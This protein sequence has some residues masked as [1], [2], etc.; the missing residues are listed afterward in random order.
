MF[1][2]VAPFQPDDKSKIQ[3]SKR[4]DFIFITLTMAKS[5]RTALHTQSS[6]GTVTLS[7]CNLWLPPASQCYQTLSRVSTAN[8]CEHSNAY[9]YFW[10]I[11]CAWVFVTFSTKSRVISCKSFRDILHK[12]LS[13]RHSSFKVTYL[14][15]PDIVSSAYR[16][17]SNTKFVPSHTRQN[18]DRCFCES[19]TRISLRMMFCV[20]TA[21][22]PVCCLHD[23]HR[24]RA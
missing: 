4:C 17:H 18:G 11:L 13:R 1:P 8:F 6:N 3:L 24:A 15:S 2:T 20:R 14:I 10:I 9:S 5:K 22:G 23:T 7:N 19:R 21:P 12:M 16:N